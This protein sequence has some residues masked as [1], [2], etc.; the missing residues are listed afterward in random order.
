ML[1]LQ[2]HY[3]TLLRLKNY[4]PFSLIDACGTLEQC[5]VQIARELRYISATCHAP[6]HLHRIS[7]SRDPISHKPQ[8]ASPPELHAGIWLSTF[9]LMYGSR[10]HMLTTTPLILAAQWHAVLRGSQSS[11]ISRTMIERPS[12]LH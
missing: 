2:Q 1:L 12:L 11:A 10:L 4:F 5:R 8:A 7:H 3:G 9:I 6:T